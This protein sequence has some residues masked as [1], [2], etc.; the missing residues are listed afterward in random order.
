MMV[1]GMEAPTPKAGGA[2]QI[3]IKTRDS[4]G[5]VFKK[6]SKSGGN[7]IIEF[8]G[9]G[10][11]LTALDKGLENSKIAWKD[12]VYVKANAKM[13]NNKVVVNSPEIYNP[14]F[15]RYAWGDTKIAILFNKE[16]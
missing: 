15:V 8:D 5:P 14:L 2:Y 10:N 4:I 9:I 13:E 1:N 3:N 11:G 6:V 16:G 7:L 12:S